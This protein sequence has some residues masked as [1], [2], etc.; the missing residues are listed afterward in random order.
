MDHMTQESWNLSLGQSTVCQQ[1]VSSYVEGVCE[2]AL[3][4]FP[5]CSVTL[6][7]SFI[8]HLLFTVLLSIQI[9]ITVVIFNSTSK[10]RLLQIAVLVLVSDYT[11]VCGSQS[12][13]INRSRRLCHL[14]VQTDCFDLDSVSWSKENNITLLG[15]CLCCC[16]SPFLQEQN[17]KRRM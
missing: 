7:L 16:I 2:C 11:P 4:F 9:R 3:H 14:S 15:A 17:T 1:M 5:D 12:L 13:S 6:P 8:L 10:S